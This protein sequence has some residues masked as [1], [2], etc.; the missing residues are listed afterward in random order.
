MYRKNNSLYLLV[1]LI[2]VVLFSLLTIYASSSVA[3]TLG[4]SARAATLY[5]PETGSFL[6]SKNADERLPMA[7]TTKIMTAVVALENSELSEVVEIDERAVG[8]EGSSAYL[9]AGDSL[10][11][12]EL[13]YAV[14]LSSAND[15]AAAIAYHISGSIEDFALLM[16]E[17]ADAL[18][19]C[20]THFTNPHGL[21]SEEHY[22]TARDLAILAGYAI[23]NETFKT[24]SSTHKKSFITEE[25]SRTYVNHN[26][27]LSM[28]DGSIGMKTGFTKRSGRCLVGAAERDGLTFIT[29]TLDA[30]NDWSDHKNMLDFGYER[31]EKITFADAGDYSYEVKL[32]DGTLSS[33]NVTN[34]EGCSTILERG[35]YDVKE[36]VKLSRYTVAPVS[37]GDILG[38]VIFTIDG[39]YSGEVN[40]VAADSVDVRQE[41]GF[42]R[43]VYDRI[44][45]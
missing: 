25:R 10:T 33:V 30:P 44:F 45:G 12:E 20:D 35:D 21:D 23:K 14:M 42:F 11:M 24:I 40:L 8:V 26:K 3:E 43:K 37:K 18:G 36:Y 39:E 1:I 28:Y 2:A 15:A 17:K 9:K 32:L 31:L 6:F 16:N 38:K 7:S 34:T 5:E 22:T 41:K 4:V 29:V 19:L 13:L 27:L